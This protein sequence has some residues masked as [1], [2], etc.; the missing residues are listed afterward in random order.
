M[1]QDIFLYFIGTAGSG[2]STVSNLFK[3]WLR[4]KGLDSIIV[5][6]DP[7]AENLP[8][9]P[10]VDIRDWISLEEVM[11]EYE[12]GPNGAQ[13][14]CADMIAL[15]TDDIKSSIESFKTDFII[16]DTPGQL[17]LF[18]FRESGKFIIDSLNPKRSVVAYLI[19]HI[20]TRN[21]IGFVSHLLLSFTTNFKLGLP[22]INLLSKTDL[23]SEDELNHVIQWAQDS[24]LLENELANQ[25]PSIYKNLN[26]Q[27]LRVTSSY[28]NNISIL[29]ISKEDYKG[30]D[31]FYTR[32]Q[33]LFE[34]GEDLLSD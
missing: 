1:K 13:V 5:N 27:I 31:D 15:N 9:K 4:I 25:N 16:M 19:D 10:D 22:Q 21:P 11:K 29:P 12:L 33:L 2:K 7:G 26:E 32:I 34:G 24:E 23:L 8:Y 30:I 28:S 14:A 20:L 18:V 6:L 17:E 3:E